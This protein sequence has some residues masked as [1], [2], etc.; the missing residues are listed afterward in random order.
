MINHRIKGDKNRILCL[1]DE[2]SK[3]MW[4]VSLSVSDECKVLKDHNKLR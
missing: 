1:K 3:P 2:Q 4:Q